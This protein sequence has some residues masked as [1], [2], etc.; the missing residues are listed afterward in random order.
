MFASIKKINWKKID[1]SAYAF[2]APV[3]LFFITFV[4]Y[5]NLEDV[6]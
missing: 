1:Y 4:L 6:I 2:I 3:M 5:P